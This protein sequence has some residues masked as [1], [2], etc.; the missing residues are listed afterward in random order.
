MLQQVKE[1][2]FEVIFV[3]AYD[4]YAIQ[5]FRFAAI[6]YLL[7]P[8]IAKDLIDA[9]Q[10]VV[11]KKERN[12]T[13]DH[14]INLLHNL[15]S[16][17]NHPPRI[18]VPLGNAIEF[19]TV[20][21]IIH[22]RADSNYTHIFVRSGEKFLLTKTLRELEDW[23]SPKDFFRCHQSHLVNLGEIKRYIKSD[24]PYVIM[25]DQSK[26]PVARRRADQFSEIIKR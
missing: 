6:D 19:V 4:Q 21:E 16:G 14:L 15:K 9:V 24:G 5:A 3:T 8:V 22:C 1:I 18:A 11:N 2:D 10:R 13:Q 25:S 26:I 12:F 7:K 17:I 23:L 20:D